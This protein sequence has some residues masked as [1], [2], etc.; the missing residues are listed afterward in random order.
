[1]GALPECLELRARLN[2]KQLAATARSA[3]A[4]SAASSSAVKRMSF[5]ARSRSASTP[6]TAN[7]SRL[8]N[9]GMGGQASARTPGGAAGRAASFSGGGGGA[10]GGAGAG[11]GALS[12][13]SARV[14]SAS[15]ALCAV[16]AAERDP[17]RVPLPPSP[18]VYPSL[19]SFVRRE[20]LRWARLFVD[21]YETPVAMDY[22][23]PDPPG[24][25]AEA[26]LSLLELAE[27]QRRQSEA[28]A[29]PAAAESE[30]SSKP[31]RSS[32]YA[33]LS[34]LYDVASF[35][36]SARAL[37]RRSSTETGPSTASNNT[38]ATP[39][40]G[41]GPSS[42]VPPG[43]PGL[44]ATISRGALHSGAALPAL[45]PAASPSFASTGSWVHSSHESR[46]SSRGQGQ[47]PAQGGAREGW[48][49][50][51]L[52]APAS[53][54]A[55]ADGVGLRLAPSRRTS[56]RGASPPRSASAG[57][58][59]AADR[60]RDREALPA[61]PAAAPAAAAAETSSTSRRRSS[62]GL[63]RKQSAASGASG[64]SG[65]LP[66]VNEAA[67][68]SRGGDGSSPVP[69][70]APAVV[71]AGGWLP[72]GEREAAQHG[73]PTAAAAARGPSWHARSGASQAVLGMAR[74]EIRHLV[75]R[76]A[77]ALERI[78]PKHRSVGPRAFWLRGLLH[79]SEGRP[80]KAART[81]LRGLRQAESQRM[82]PDA[83]LLCAELGA[84]GR[85]P[86]VSEAAARTYADRAAAFFERAGVPAYA[87]RYGFASSAASSA[88]AAA[89]ASPPPETA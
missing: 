68:S 52:S 89:P 80:D 58:A 27:A 13:P 86:H 57:A 37:R 41:Q 3:A 55:D 26:L 24:L 70:G 18:F 62:S 65:L 7:S 67:G 66:T 42:P 79:D 12:M 45:G 64:A 76:L 5:S 74:E 8:L 21:M 6:T 53:A 44:A 81:W 82:P 34:S 17:R 38:V 15:A 85:P 11:A 88:P 47:G 59:A 49:P 2:L 39:L 14:L 72:G 61:A 25:V 50:G 83:A 78:A 71:F 69:P 1:M 84:R 54:I 77:R 56:V 9:G 16:G 75:R 4:S 43:S 60:D 30:V 48:G 23:C 19:T 29:A 31:R 73:S 36:T 20:A 33:F 28:D 46:R 10:S 40:R 63:S 22:W 87:R 32:V 35:G 51:P